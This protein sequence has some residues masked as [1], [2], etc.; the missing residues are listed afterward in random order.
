MQIPTR[1]DLAL[2]LR[3][4]TPMV[5]H[6]PAELPDVVALVIVAS[7]LRESCQL[8]GTVEGDRAIGDLGRHVGRLFQPSMAVQH[9]LRAV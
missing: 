2:P 7:M 6:Q 3:A 4:Q 8:L 9:K 1:G 5:S